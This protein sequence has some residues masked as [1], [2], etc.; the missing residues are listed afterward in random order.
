MR[1]NYLVITAVS[2]VFFLIAGCQ[3]QAKKAEEPTEAA[4]SKTAGPKIEFESMVYDFGKV[5]PAQILNGEFKLTNTGDAP[6]KIT[7]V[8]KC[9]GAVT[10]LDKTEFEPGESGVLHVRYT[11]SRTAYKMMKR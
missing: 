8:E 1:R 6:L 11:S 3:Q 10:Q 4:E 7:N 9:C 2:C 5:G